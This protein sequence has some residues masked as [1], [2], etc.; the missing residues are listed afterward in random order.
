MIERYRGGTVPAPKPAKDAA[1]ALDAELADTAT[2]AA[3]KVE[4]C[5]DRFVFNRAME[6]IWNVVSRTN[7]YIDETAPW[8]LAKDAADADRLDTVLYNLAESLRILS[9]LIT[10]FMHTTAEEIR[11]QLGIADEPALWE[12][13]SR[14]GKLG[15]A[16]VKKGAALFPRID[17]DKELEALE[18]I[19]TR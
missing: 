5:M 16:T 8:V 6:E 19:N 10:P 18:A 1:A 14:F 9:V 2:A 3:A 17:I 15:R 4:H 11:R 7:K 12:D 13:A